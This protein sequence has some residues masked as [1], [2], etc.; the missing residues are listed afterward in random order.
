[1]KRLIL[2]VPLVCGGCVGEQ[3]RAIFSVRAPARTIEVAADHSAEHGGNLQRALDESIRKQEAADMAEW[4]AVENQRAP[5][6]IVGEAPCA[7][8]NL[9]TETCESP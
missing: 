3:T 9:D 7:V 1:M 6:A 8:L 5:V 4:K 2:L